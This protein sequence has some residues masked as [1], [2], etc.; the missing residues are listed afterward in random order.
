[1]DAGG[2]H[3]TALALR[4]F[5]VFYATTLQVLQKQTISCLAQGLIF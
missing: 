1:M 3:W 5:Q 2:L 4:M